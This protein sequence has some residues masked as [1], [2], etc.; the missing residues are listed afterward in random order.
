MSGRISEQTLEE[1]RARTDIVELIGSR[2]PLKRASADFKACC[3]F[4]KEKTP[5]FIVSP[6]RRTFHCFGCGAH[7]DVFKYLMMS[8]GMTFVDAVRF[9]AQRCGVTLD[10]AE[11]YEAVERGVLMRINAELA[12][13]YQRCLRQIAEASK[14]R[15]YLASRKL[16]GETAERFGIGYAPDRQGTILAW[17]A[18]HGF[19]AEQLVT[20]G[21]LTPPKEGRR[22]DDYYD[23]FHG[24]LMFP[25]RNA[26]GQVIGFSGRI[27]DANAK[28]AKYVNSPETPV[29]HKGSVLYA[30]DFARKNIVR[31]S[32]REALVC[33]GQIDVIRCHASGFGN[34]VA[35]QGT[36]F[37]EEHVKL[38]KRYADS[39]LLVFDGDAAGLH[40]AVRTGRLF[41]QEG[42]PVQVAS[43]PPGEDP[44]SIIRDKGSEAFR[45]I[46]DKPE[47]LVAFQIRSMREAEAAP[48]ALDARARITSQVIE[49]V[50]SCSQAVMRSYLEQEAAERLGVPLDALQSD[51][52]AFQE[53]KVNAEKWRTDTPAANSGP[54]E[55]VKPSNRQTVKPSAT[56]KPSNRQTVKRPAESPLFSLAQLLLQTENDATLVAR[57]AEWLP[58][59]IMGG[60]L[61]AQAVNAALA[62]AQ[63][64]TSYIADLTDNGEPAMKALIERLSTQ[65]AKALS[66]RELTPVD[67]ANDLITRVWIDYFKKQRD[68]L[69]LA[70]P[71]ECKRRF[72]L[73][74]TIKA[75]E[76]THDWDRRANII[77]PEY[78]RLAQA[79][80]T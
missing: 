66:S 62:D 55:T 20:V 42:M 67:A 19:T 46:L 70:K 41:L 61:E 64:G 35:S 8:D 4:H 47:S 27:L 63:D 43:L 22:P 23:R 7:G 59:H 53:K 1:I 31:D 58:E 79:A 74:A 24:R 56:V 38:L 10:L 29:F 65:E 33:E 77:Y 5:S 60:S 14:A 28:A 44:D 18:K 32:R 69:D 25:I 34:A 52:A 78:E 54:S 40:A 12:A 21:V 6:A 51:I 73:S 49:T 9:L 57:V 75:L 37:T 17:A 36:A 50:T 30:L 3:P 76:S 71:E 2:I 15:D 68:G 80:E 16:D 26:T 13:F 39:A 48:D 11:D 45:A 72:E